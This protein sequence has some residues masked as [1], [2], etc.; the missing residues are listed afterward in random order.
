MDAATQLSLLDL[1][2]QPGEPQPPG[3]TENGLVALA[4][5]YL[6]D[7]VMNVFALMGLAEEEIAAAKDRYP[8]ATE[9]VYDAFRYLAPS[10]LLRP[11]P[12]GDLYRGHC[13]EIIARLVAG[14]DLRPATDAELLGVFSET[15]LDA[16]LNGLGTLL[17]L[18]AFINVYGPDTV[19]IPERDMVYLEHHHQQNAA[20]QL[21]ELRHKFAVPTRDSR[22]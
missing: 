7:R 1:L 13:R 9:L 20:V 16:P 22:N 3:S 15:S 18:Q 2:V 17:Y 14:Q 21:E 11:Y 5:S 6:G 8:Q 10:P 19:A 4:S 12:P